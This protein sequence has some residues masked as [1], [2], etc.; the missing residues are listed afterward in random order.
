[1]SQ[2]INFNIH[3]VDVDVDV[4]TDFTSFILNNLLNDSFYSNTNDAMETFISISLLSSEFPIS[5]Y[6]QSFISENILNRTLE[7]SMN[8]NS[9]E[10]RDTVLN[11]SSQTYK[12]II[13]KHNTGCAICLDK[14]KDDEMVSVLNDCKHVFHT[15]CIMEAGQYKP[16]CPL[17][18][19]NIPILE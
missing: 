12:S 18:R 19:K 4:E 8:S 2:N 1:M 13:S 10:K 15:T 7:E 9:N 6:Q 5:L 3:D 14:F 11:I 16:E 17:C